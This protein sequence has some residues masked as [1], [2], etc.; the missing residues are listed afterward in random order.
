MFVVGNTKGWPL[1]ITFRD[2]ATFGGLRRRK[3]SARETLQI[4]VRKCPRSVSC[5][6]LESKDYRAAQVVAGF[7]RFQHPILEDVTTSAI[8]STE[9]TQKEGEKK[10]PRGL[11]CVCA[12]GPRR[13]EAGHARS[14]EVGKRPDVL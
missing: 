1:L 11:V 5:I 4:P 3:A 6:N 12:G 7:L 2:F 14:E 8:A 9:E 10:A 13:A